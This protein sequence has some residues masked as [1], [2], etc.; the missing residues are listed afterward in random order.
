MQLTEYDKSLLAGKEGR[1]LQLAME[2]M[3]KYGEAVGAEKLIDCSYVN[4]GIL[5]PYPSFRVNGMD[6]EDVDKWFSYLCLDSLEEVKIPP[7]KNY[8]AASSTS[9][10]RELLDFLKAD[11]EYYRSL[12]ILDA[13]F[14]KLG[15]GG[16][17]TCAPSTVGHC[18]AMG[19]H[20]AVGESSAV[21]YYNSVLGARTNCEGTTAGLCAALTQRIP[22]F[23]MHT[24]EGR[25]GTHLIKIECKPKTVAD[26]DI[27][28]YY[29][30]KEIVEGLPV[31]E[32]DV[33][34][35]TSDMHKGLGT[36]VCSSGGVLM[37]H[38]IGHT[39]EANT[40]EQA[41][42]V[43][44]PKDVLVYDDAARKKALERLNFSDSEDVD[45][46]M[47]GC[48]H[49]SLEQIRQAAGYLC[50]K[51]VKTT[52]IINTARQTKQVADF[53]G[54]TKMIEDAGGH[55]MVDGCSNMCALWPEG[56]HV[57]ATDSGKCSHYTPSNRPDLG[58]HFGSELQ[59][60]EAAVTGKWIWED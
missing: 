4:V 3:V 39:P 19:E 21:V 14:K 12:D 40:L 56:I 29:V 2:L 48:P 60:L 55:L 18:P 26:Y 35:V 57:M 53:T 32:G 51:K 37:Y 59:C 52:L 10:S 23:G 17:Y 8:V 22:Y 1:A 36:S 41:F 28:G 5:S 31:F 13:L 54:Y 49:Y 33:G 6:M 58:I 11:K 43:N 7:F 27:M 24:D 45:M 15:A 46:V 44:K 50:N 16:D 42:Q 25:A 30:G 34:V 9:P 20:C 38:F 47:I